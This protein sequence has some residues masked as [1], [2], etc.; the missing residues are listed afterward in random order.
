MCLTIHSYLVLAIIVRAWKGLMSGLLSM[1]MKFYPRQ[2]SLR[3]SWISQLKITKILALIVNLKLKKLNKVT[4]D[5]YKSCK[6]T[7]MIQEVATRVHRQRQTTYSCKSI[8]DIQE[9]RNH[10]MFPLNR[11][12]SIAFS[13]K[14]RQS[15]LFR[16]I[17]VKSQHKILSRAF[18]ISCILLMCFRQTG[19][20]VMIYL[21]A[22]P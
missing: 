16:K 22:Q 20:Q 6:L 10:N 3:N 7:L 19:F 14:I 4:W 8:L 1:Q 5:S 15:H 11:G 2:R 13:K 18:R 12:F 9:I 21:R 17:R